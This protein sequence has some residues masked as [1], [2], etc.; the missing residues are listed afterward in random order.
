MRETYR[1]IN[2]MLEE[3]KTTITGY[4]ADQVPRPGKMEH[5]VEFL[6]HRTAAIVGAE[7]ITKSNNFAAY[8]AEISR[9]KRGYYTIYFRC[10]HPQP[11]TLPDFE[12]T[13]IFYRYLEETINRQPELYLWTH[14]RFKRASTL[15][16]DNQTIKPTEQ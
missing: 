8:Y 13:T 12:L 10:L 2:T 15:L 14:N 16:T 11:D 1:W 3:G 4:V 6:N 9:Q 7:K 5:F